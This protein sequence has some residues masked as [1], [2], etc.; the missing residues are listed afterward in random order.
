MNELAVRWVAEKSWTYRTTFPSPEKTDDRARTDLVFKGLDTFAR[1]SLNGQKILEADNMFLEYRVEVGQL[2][3]PSDGAHTNDLQIVFDS[4]LVRGRELVKQHEHEHDFIAHQTEQ[5]RLPV[6]KAQCHW[7][8]DWGPI[9]VTAGPWRPILLETYVRRIDDVWFQAVVSPDLA[10]V[11]GKL[12]A[13]ADVGNATAVKFNLSLEGTLTFE[14]QVEVNGQGLASTDFHIERPALW[15]PYGHGQQSRYKLTATLLEGD[16]ELTSTSKL[17]GFRRCQL[18]Q[19]KDQHGKSF[20]FRI[21]NVDVFC[22]GSCWIPADSFIPR[23]GR[24]GY[25]KWMQ[26][27]IEGNQN[28]TRWVNRKISYRSFPLA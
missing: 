3:K 27:M 28:M 4:A 6:R 9:L 25:R 12:L 8:W 22:G 17:V 19:E 13:T 23:V 10:T 7:G 24:D 1:V 14:S 20:Y 2:L 21:N 18:I 16:A 5:S 26:L 15:N 11:S